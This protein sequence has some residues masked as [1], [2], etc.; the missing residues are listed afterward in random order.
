[1]RYVLGISVI[2][3]V[4]ALTSSVRAQSPEV[5]ISA[6]TGFGTFTEPFRGNEGKSQRKVLFGAEVLFRPQS[7]LTVGVS[8]VFNGSIDP[9][10]Y[11]YQ[12]VGTF[13]YPCS[14]DT[15]T[16]SD[17]GKLFFASGYK[18]HISLKAMVIPSL[19][20][21]LRPENARVRPFLGGG[22]GIAWTTVEY[23]DLLLYIDPVY[24][25]LTGAMWD[26]TMRPFS[27]GVYAWKA[28]A[29]LAIR[30]TDSARIRG[31]VKFINRMAVP[32]VGVQFR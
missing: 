17:P 22:I 13:N 2:V 20:Y 1:M 29:G 7:R 31:S 8:G 30:I 9:K 23:R 12:I 3:T 24:R 11:L 26:A 14:T 21:N 6:G 32:M 4:F 16:Y 5:V 25:Q 19:Y 10:P 18:P 15:C 27:Q 28:E